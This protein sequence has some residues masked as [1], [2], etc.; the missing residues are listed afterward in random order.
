MTMSSS[1]SAIESVLFFLRAQLMA[2]RPVPAD[3]DVA[4]LAA[5]KKKQK[6]LA[7]CNRERR[8]REQRE[9]REKR[10]S[11]AAARRAAVKSHNR[12]VRA[13]TA[14]VLAEHKKAM[15]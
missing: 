7:A 2:G 8:E 6:A 10:A 14:R 3:P 15:A 12:A 1:T 9:L 11:L 4:R 13:E 5:L